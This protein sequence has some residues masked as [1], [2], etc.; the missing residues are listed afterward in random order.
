[1]R[2][3]NRGFTL[4]EL[5]AAMVILG[6]L[7]MIAVPTIFNMFDDNKKQLYV[8]AAKKLMAQ[9]EYEMKASSSIIEKP[10]KDGA[11]AISLLYLDSSDFE[12]APE[13]G[14][15][16]KEASFVVIKNTGTSLEYSATIVEKM[17]K[18]GYKGVVLTKGTALEKKNANKYVKVFNK[19]KIVYIEDNDSGVDYLSVNYINDNLGT[20]YIKTLDGIYNYPELVGGLEEEGDDTPVIENV[21]I[22]PAD[23]KKYN[24]FDAILSVTANDDKTLRKDLMVYTS[25]VSYDDALREANGAMY[26]SGDSYQKAYNFSSIHNKYDG[27]E[28]TVY[29]VVKDG[30]GSIAMKQVTY[31]LHTNTAPI[32]NTN[33]SVTYLAKRTNDEHNMPKA[34][35]RLD[36]SDDVDDKV[37]LDVCISKTEG[38]CTAYK[39]YGEV[40]GNN[41]TLEYDF[42]GNPDGRTV[43]LFVYVRD[44]F[45]L[46]THTELSYNIYNNIGPTIEGVEIVSEEDM[47][48]DEDRRPS[49]GGHLTTYIKVIAT[50]DFATSGLTVNISSPSTNAL[51]Y[52]YS[53]EARKFVLAGNYDGGER[54]IQVSV[55]DQF[56]KSATSTHKYRVYK[57]K[58]PVIDNFTIES[59]G[60]ACND[61]SKC[62]ISSGGSI[63]TKIS[64][65]VTDDIDYSGDYA[66][67]KVCVS[68]KA[69][70]NGNFVPY[71]D[72]H[73]KKV[74]FK[75]TPTNSDN[76]YDGSTKK[77]Y[78]G[79]ID[80]YGEVSLGE[81][82][83]KLYNNQSP[84]INSLKIESAP[85]S[86]MLESNLF[87]DFLPI[88]INSMRITLDVSDDGDKPDL[89]VDVCKKIGSET[90]TCEGYMPY[91]EVFDVSLLDSIESDRYDGREYAIKVRVKDPFGAVAE[92]SG[93]YK[94]YQDKKPVIDK[95]TIESSTI[96]V[97]DRV[98]N[99]E[100][101]VRDPL[102]TFD[103]CLG[104]SND[105]D[106]CVANPI[107]YYENNNGSDVKDDNV[108]YVIPNDFDGSTST[109]YLIV[110]DSYGHVVSKSVTYTLYNMCSERSGDTTEFSFLPV[111]ENEIISASKC[112]GKCY[113]E[114]NPSNIQAKYNYSL[115]YMDKYFINYN[116]YWLFWRNLLY[117]CFQPIK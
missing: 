14:E 16:I 62:P 101:R 90:E 84:V 70:N 3:N 28:I 86:E 103:L 15:F 54:T 5:L 82:S 29:V 10:P 64:F 89:M 106:T 76:P 6:I 43:K 93:T 22:S 78:Y 79:V 94:V 9:A 11:I 46:I 61:S 68:D 59:D 69:A 99:F 45:G 41:D 52:K 83:Y 49:I 21:S 92:K 115:S 40:F 113:T 80:T 91:R 23:N 114:G 26:G 55:T 87:E 47:F 13:G 72:Y 77:I 36:V 63:N 95:F 102:D 42:G 109:Y 4:V 88:N 30:G 20:N 112:G 48:T 75:V 66:D 58:P 27:Y 60:E 18:G 81:T 12:D 111:D 74:D 108:G 24:S 32:I 37:D 73:G 7:M 1:M 117:Y 50:D 38:S 51:E 53:D 96:G 8:D 100:F 85:L 44:S 35:L 39:K 56:G 97:A 2:K 34:Q 67:L 116:H 71:G 98:V 31:T 25:L 57:N 19:D 105:F 110:K 17:K 65:S 104:T 107:R 33:S